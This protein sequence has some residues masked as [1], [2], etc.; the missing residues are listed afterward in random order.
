[1]S[2]RHQEQEQ[3]DESRWVPTSSILDFETTPEAHAVLEKPTKN[4]PLPYD[5]GLF[6]H[7]DSPT[8]WYQPPTPISDA[9]PA[10]TSCQYETS[11]TADDYDTCIVSFA[12]DTSS[13]NGAS[14]APDHDV[15]MEQLTHKIFASSNTDG[16]WAEEMDQMV[17][18][19]EYYSPNDLPTPAPPSPAPLHPPLPPTS[20]YTPQCLLFCPYT[21]P[22]RTRC[23]PFKKQ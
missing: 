9:Q 10:P 21:H 8:A 11:N 15:M 13:D 3:Q 2:A 1:M 22:Q 20:S 4:A 17:L 12:G 23:V 16:N 6:E 14:T 19:G 7:G 5:D 18:Q